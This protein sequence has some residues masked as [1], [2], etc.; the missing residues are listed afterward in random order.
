MLSGSDS[1]VLKMKGYM[2]PLMT[3]MRVNF[4]DKWMILSQDLTEFGGS[5]T[6]KLQNSLLTLTKGGDD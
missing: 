3:F 2:D 4:E 5:H 6:Y 1:K